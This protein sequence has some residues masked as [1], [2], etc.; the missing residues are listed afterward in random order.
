[1]GPVP[2]SLVATVTWHVVGLHGVEQE[3]LDWLVA[4]TGSTNDLAAR[5]IKTN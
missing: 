1:M 2:S 5:E 4:A 3:A